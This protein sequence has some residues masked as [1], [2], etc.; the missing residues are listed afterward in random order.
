MNPVTR[1]E[2]RE[3]QEGAEIEAGDVK[4]PKHN[5]HAK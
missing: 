4:N 3:G 1:E 5:I 2:S